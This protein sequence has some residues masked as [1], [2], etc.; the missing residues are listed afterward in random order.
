MCSITP[1]RVEEGL[2]HSV[3]VVG[4]VLRLKGAKGLDQPKAE[5]GHVGVGRCAAW[6]HF[7]KL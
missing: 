4:G 7:P 2:S 3:K 1:P 5:T 6:H